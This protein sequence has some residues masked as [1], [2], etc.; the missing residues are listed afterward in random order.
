MIETEQQRNAEH[1]RTQRSTVKQTALADAQL[2]EKR[3]RRPQL[4]QQGK[5]PSERSMLTQTEPE[6]PRAFHCP[7][8]RGP[9]RIQP[10]RNGQTGENHPERQTGFTQQHRAPAQ[11]HLGQYHVDHA[12]RQC[13]ECCCK[14]QMLHQRKLQTKANDRRSEQHRAVDVIA[15]AR[16]PV[17]QRF[18]IAIRRCIGHVE[19]FAAGEQQADGEVHQEEQDQERLG[20]P[21]QFRRIRTKAPGEADAKGADETNQVEQTPGFEPGDGKNAGVE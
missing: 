8:R 4:Q 13:T 15:L 18:A 11:Q 21:Q 1:Q 20:A 16:R 5:R 6:N 14:F 9:A 12:Q 7:C 3:Q 10:Q 2:T 17:Q 19:Q